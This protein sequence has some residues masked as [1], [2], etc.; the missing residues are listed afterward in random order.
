M[1][2]A[3]QAFKPAKVTEIDGVSVS[4]D[5]SA[6]PNCTVEIFLDDVDAIAEALQSLA[7]VTAAADGS[8][9]A[10]LPFELSPSQ[11]LRT[12]ST[13]A[14]FNTIPGMGAGTTTGL[15]ALYVSGHEV[16]L[17]LVQK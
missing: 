8:W 10:T 13:T 12:T 7:V 16:Y 15:S 6:C 17:P 3:F 14:Q 2:E 1:S 4:G 9:S 11:G 5:G